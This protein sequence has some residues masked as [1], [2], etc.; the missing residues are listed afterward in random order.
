MSTGPTAARVRTKRKLSGLTQREVAYL[1]GAHSP[2]SVSKHERS[3]AVPDLIIALGYEIIF[4][5]PV[6][7]LFGELSARIEEDIERRAVK[8]QDKLGRSN[9]KG[10]RGALTARKL[11]FLCMRLN[12]DSTKPAK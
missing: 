9:A 3:D 1:L 7:V 4:H 11:E 5:E 6:S 8:L 2:A 10:K 12:P